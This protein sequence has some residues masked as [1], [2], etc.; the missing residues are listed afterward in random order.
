MD[1]TGVGAAADPFTREVDLFIARRVRAARIFAGLR[2]ED[3]AGAVGLSVPQL[4]RVERGRRSLS[5]PELLRIAM[6][7]AR[8][9]AYFIEPPNP[10]EVVRTGWEKVPKRSLWDELST[11]D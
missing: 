8:P 9:I 11:L 5:V 7:T 1:G 2:Q 10:E 6:Q 4:C 3:L